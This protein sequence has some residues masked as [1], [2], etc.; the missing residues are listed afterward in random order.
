MK[1]KTAMV[2]GLSVIFGCGL[3][4]SWYTLYEHNRQLRELLSVVRKDRD[5]QLAK[6]IVLPTAI[7]RVVGKSQVWRP[8]QESVKDAV[9]QIFVQGAE[10]DI[11]QP[12]ATPA[13]F[14]VYGSGFFINTNGEFIT[15]EHVVRNAK[16]IWIQI[17]SLGKRIID[18]I[19]V[20]ESPDRDIAL[21]RVTDEGKRIIE[22]ELGGVKC[23]KFG[24]SDYVRRSDEVMALG[25]PLGQQALKSTT[26]VISGRE[27]GMIQISAAINPGNSGGPLMNSAGEVIGINASKITS[28]QV[29]N[30]GYMIPINDLKL[31][32][33]DLRSTKLVRR[34]FL[35]VILTNGTEAL[36]EYLG[37]PIPGGC[38]VADVVKNSTLYKAGVESGDMIYEINGCKV[39]IY[40]EMSVNWAEDRVSFVDYVGRLVV[41]EDIRFVVYRHGKRKEFSVKFTEAELPAVRQVYPWLEQVDYEVFAGMV[42]MQ[43]T[44]NHVR[45]LVQQAPGLMSYTEMKNQAE[46]VLIVTNVFPTSQLYRSRTLI[47]GVTL[48]EINGI[49]VHTLDELRQAFLAHDGTCITIRATDQVMLSSDNIF[50]V[51]PYQKVLEEEPLLS[52]LYKYPLSPTAKTLLAQCAQTIQQEVHVAHAQVPA[53]RVQAAVG[54][55]V[56]A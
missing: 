5:D 52:Q 6:N 34:P 46:P 10:V 14:T 4:L 53:P 35:G 16:Q 30:I 41:G 17:P 28:S 11:L 15:N 48:N 38:Y 19:V 36:T 20:G 31:L 21:L 37:N 2:S 54:N 18:A 32:L 44:A 3:A 23:L 13:Q 43:L 50:V 29:D 42:V 51:L 26:G 12:Y 8:V 9:V 7:E 24:D 39:D 40:G 45:A 55:K 1:L 33:D 56:T 27:G 22:R 49:P 47:A 25:Y